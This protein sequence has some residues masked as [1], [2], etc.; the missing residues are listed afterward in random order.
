M[1]FQAVYIDN[2]EGDRKQIQ[3]NRIRWA[4]SLYNVLKHRSFF[5]KEIDN[6]AF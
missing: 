4:F 5:G 2:S 3:E 1:N 6:G